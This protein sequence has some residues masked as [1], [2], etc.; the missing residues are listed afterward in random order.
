MVSKNTNFPEDCNA[1]TKNL[2]IKSKKYTTLILKNIAISIYALIDNSKILSESSSENLNHSSFKSNYTYENDDDFYRFLRNIYSN[3]EI[4]SPVF[5]HS[6]ILIN[7]LHHDRKFL[8][9]QNTLHNYF[10]IVLTISIKLLLE[11]RYYTYFYL[12]HFKIEKKFY[13]K[14]EKD[15]LELSNYKIYFRNEVYEIFEN[16]LRNLPQI[17]SKK[18]IIIKRKTK[19]LNFIS[20]D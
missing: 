13:G 11:N 8:I 15:L 5:I 1:L 19:S 14:L 3:C 4:E 20:F 6:F 2:Y 16:Y 9:S 17:L 7:T 10:C 12:H 18:E